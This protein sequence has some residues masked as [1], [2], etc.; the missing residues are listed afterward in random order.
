METT[1]VVFAAE[2]IISWICTVLGISFAAALALYYGEETTK[3]TT[4]TK[5]VE[6]AR[7][8]QR[9]EGREIH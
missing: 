5:T 2:P 9:N 3:D 7:N 6:E 1:A 4:E 8:K